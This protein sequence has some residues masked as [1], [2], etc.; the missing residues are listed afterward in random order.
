MRFASEEW[1][2]C[3]SSVV[4]L[5]STHLHIFFL[6]NKNLNLV[7][8][9]PSTVLYNPHL[10]FTLLSHKQAPNTLPFP[11]GLSFYLIT[12]DFMPERRSQQVLKVQQVMSNWSFG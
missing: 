10:Y 5:K 11:P 6:P 8:P 2:P 4:L 7:L 12:C 9:V 1:C 3:S